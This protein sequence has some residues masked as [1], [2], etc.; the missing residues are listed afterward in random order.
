M[1]KLIIKIIII[2]ILLYVIFELIKPKSIQGFTQPIPKTIYLSYKTKDIPDYIIPTWKKLNPN[3]DVKVYDN[4][5]CIAF[6]KAYY[7]DPIYVD[8]FNY[9]KDGPIKADYWRVCILNKFG[10]VYSD[11]DVKPM[12]PINEF[13][14][15]GVTFLTC[16]SHI[17]ALK[18]NVNP[19]LIITVPNHPVLQKCIDI[20]LTKYKNNDKYSYW[21]WSIVNI[22][23]DAINMIFDK[24][25]SEGIEYDKDNNK[26]QFLQEIMPT[27][28][29]MPDLFYIMN[30]I[31][32]NKDHHCVYKGK[33][34]LYNRYEDYTDH[35]FVSRTN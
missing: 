14:E 7:N 19:H 4:N 25:I 13:L 10:G 20:Y 5:D 29:N 22:M 3:Y 28:F 24:K 31:K 9:I 2:I 21:G 18:N 33:V 12:V 8:I 35:G 23:R 17:T 11:I 34:I 32:G 30:K 16:L 27:P 6:L 26:Y 15:E 1:L